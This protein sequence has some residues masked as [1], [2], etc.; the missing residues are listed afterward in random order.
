[1]PGLMQPIQVPIEN[2][3]ED[4]KKQMQTFKG[5]VSAKISGGKYVIKAGNNGM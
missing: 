2:L 1:M 3:S 4:V 5:P